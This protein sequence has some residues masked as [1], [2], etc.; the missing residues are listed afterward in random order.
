MTDFIEIY[1]NVLTSEECKTLR[2]IID[3]YPREE[4]KKENEDG[5]IKHLWYVKD[6]FL[7]EPSP[8][9]QNLLKVLNDCTDRYVKKHHQLERTDAPWRL[10]NGYCMQKYDPDMGYYVSHAENQGYGAISTRRMLV[11]M[12]YLN[13]ITDG[14]GTYFENFDRSV[15]AVEGRCVIWPAYW[16]HF[17]NGIVSKTESKYITTGWYMYDRWETNPNRKERGTME[18]VLTNIINI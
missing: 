5:V 1:D 9:T 8:H 6:T 2:D 13:T 11:W 15:N 16:T 7:N 18:E 12:I 17:H 3:T 4:V 10:D 14:G